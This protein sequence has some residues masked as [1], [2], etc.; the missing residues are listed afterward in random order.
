VAE[1]N[2]RVRLQV[3]NATCTDC[4]LA[5]HTNDSLDICVTGSGPENASVMVV[6]K[7]IGGRAYHQALSEGF[8]RAGLDYRDVFHTA[9][10]KCRV[11]DMDPSVRDVKACRS[12]LDREI[13]VVKPG[14]ILALGNEA[15]LSL[16]GHSGIMNYRGKTFD[17]SS[18]AKV[19]ATISPAM[20]IRNPRMADGFAGDLAYFAA[21]VTGKV[22]EREPIEVRHVMTLAGLKAMDAEISAAGVEVAS[23]DVESTGFNEWDDDSRL[24]SISISVKTSSNEIINYAIPLYHPSSPFRKDWE[25]V[26][27][28]V[29]RILQRAQKRVAHNGKFDLRWMR[30]FAPVDADFPLTFDT[31]LAAHLLDEARTKALKPLCQQLLGAEPWGIDTRDLLRTPLPEVLEYNGLDTYWTLRLYEH[32]RG[33]LMKQPRLAKIM[34]HL[35]VGASEEITRAEA[36]AIYVDQPLL[37]ANWATA[38][39]KLLEIEDYLGN[40]LPAERPYPINFNPS[41][42]LRWFLFEHLG[43]PVLARGKPKDDGRPGDPSVSEGVM[44]ELAEQHEVPKL[45]LERTNWARKCGSFFAPWSEQLTEDSR[46]HTTFKLTGT[47]T[48]RLSSGKPDADKVTAKKQVRGF[49]MQQVPRDPLMRGCFG[50]RPGWWFVQ[51]DQSQVELRIAAEASSERNMIWHYQNG[52]DL[53]TAMA[54]RM[55]GKSKTEILADPIL[56]VQ[57]KEIRKR[58]KPVNFGYLYGMSWRK[59]QETAWLNYGLRFTDAEAQASRAAYFEMWPDLVAWHAKQ[60]RLVRKY[61]RVESPLGRVR[62]LPDILSPN[63]EVQAE[64]ERQAINS[65]V[66]SLASDITLLALTNISR[67]FRTMG[68]SSIVVG[69]VHDSILFEIPEEEMSTALPLIKRTMENPPL[70]KL[71]G[72]TMRVPLVADITVG[73]HW[74]GD[75]KELTTEQALAWDPRIMEAA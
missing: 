7:S 23:F 62:H 22:A 12:F 9:A 36:N 64:A 35:L 47:V 10:V 24:V 55:M 73:R 41:K 42:F 60:K 58:A 65:P 56:A 50:A 11:W 37:E 29:C 2:K 30:E 53:H 72:Y 15:L 54:E 31:M 74:A 33:D 40:W 16:T 49:N 52:L 19:F 34:A 18:G 4:R 57:W 17:H 21:L 67:T 45:L 59:F 66:Q 13:D 3:R 1:M 32:L 26:L 61:H 63:R 25:K 6:S 69:T 5:E 75:T 20:V 39:I 68:M 43:L 46:L 8:A 51:G 14:W 38:K 48:G 28:F 27:R 71:F 44:M 70:E